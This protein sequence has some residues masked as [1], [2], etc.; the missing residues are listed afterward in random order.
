MIVIIVILRCTGPLWPEGTY[1]LLGSLIAHLWISLRLVTKPPT[2][3]IGMKSIS[4]HGNQV[5]E[6]QGGVGA[7]WESF[8]EKVCFKEHFRGYNIPNYWRY[9]KPTFWEGVNKLVTEGRKDLGSRV[10]G[11]GWIGRNLLCFT[12]SRWSVEENNQEWLGETAV[13]LGGVLWVLGRPREHSVGW[14]PPSDELWPSS[15][16]SAFNAHSLFL[17]RPQ[18]S[19]PHSPK[20]GWFRTVFMMH[21][22]GENLYLVCMSL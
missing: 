12:L 22:T 10:R 11:R 8:P 21:L 3:Q 15:G 4:A 19:Q 16:P 5:I 18:C 20:C 14:R 13:A 17:I 2:L 1:N 9:K 7:I 6:H